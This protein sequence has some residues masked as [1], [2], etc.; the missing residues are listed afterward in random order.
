MG[1]NAKRFE[2]KVSAKGGIFLSVHAPEGV[3]R[4]VLGYV[5]ARNA[6]DPVHKTTVR[7]IMCMAV[8]EYIQKHPL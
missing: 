5:K 6:K 7:E 8:V 2:Q 1:K 4:A 3:G